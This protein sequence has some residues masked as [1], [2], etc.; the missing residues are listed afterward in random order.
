MNTLQDVFHKAQEAI[1]N[2][3]I[4]ILEKLPLLLLAGLLVLLGW[5]VA[6]GLR[7]LVARLAMVSRLETFLEKA[8]LNKVLHQLKVRSVGHLLGQVVYWAVMLGTVMLVAETLSLHAITE[9]IQRI[10]GYMPSLFASICVFLFG[11][12]LADKARFV[13]GSVGAAMGMEAGKAM[14]RILFIIILLFISITAL[15]VAGIDTTLITSNIL[16]VVGSL[17]IAFSIAYGFAARDLLSNILAGYYNKERLKPGMRVR[18]GIDEGVVER[19]SGISVVLRVEGRMV[20]IPSSR[21]VVERVEIIDVA[22][23]EGRIAP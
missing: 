15:N 17:F 3:S 7:W 2:A 8:G 9:G 12:W 4:R 11:F 14:G 18:I 22:D 10:F 1:L 23:E 13:M 19:V 6:R 5:L 21:L 20:H 16:I